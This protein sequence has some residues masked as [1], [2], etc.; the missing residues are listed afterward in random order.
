E[1]QCEQRDEGLFE[2]ASGR[3]V[4][5]V[6]PVHIL[7]CPVDMDPLMAVCDRLGVPVVEDATESLGATY[8]GKNVGTH[9]VSSCFSFNGNKLLTTGGGGMIATD[10]DETARRAKHLTTQAKI[11]EVEFVHD[12]VGFNYRLP[13]V[14]AAI[15]VAQLERLDEYVAKKKEIA[16]LYRQ[17]LVRND[18]LEL[19]PPHGADPCHWLYTLRFGQHSSRDLMKSLSSCGIQTRPLWQPIHR[20]PAHA[21]LHGS[22]PVADALNR[23]CLSLPCSVGLGRYDQERVIATIRSMI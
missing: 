16:N 15:G 2:K 4:A 3:R 6:V 10:C 13:N 14:A 20:S 17:E 12:E 8:R 5:A 9:G 23:S 18:T 7:G 11:D 1:N 19:M 22:F 21:S